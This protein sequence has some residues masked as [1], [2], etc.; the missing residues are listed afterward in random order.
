MVALAINTGIPVSA[1]LAED[2][3]TIV[4]AMH[5]LADARARE[6]QDVTGDL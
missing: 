3:R 1:W 4:T 2:D 6:Q 5:M